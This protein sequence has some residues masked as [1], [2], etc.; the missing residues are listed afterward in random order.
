MNVTWDPIPLARSKGFILFYRVSYSRAVSIRKRQSGTESVAGNQTH[1]II[2]NLDPSSQYSVTVN[3]ETSAGHGESS[4][5]IVVARPAAATSVGFLTTTNIVIIGSVGVALFIL[6]I[7]VVIVAVGCSR[8]QKDRLVAVPV[9]FTIVWPSLL[10]EN[11][12]CTVHVYT[13]TVI[14]EIFMLCKFSHG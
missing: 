9:I 7:I 3:A 8:R 2:R 14:W 4:E 12:K 1:A 10:V 5:V 11:T 13:C 6:V